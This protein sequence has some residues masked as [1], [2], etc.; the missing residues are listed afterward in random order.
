[1]ISPW[2][3]AWIVFFGLLWAVYEQIEKYLPKEK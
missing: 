2:C 1:M 3:F